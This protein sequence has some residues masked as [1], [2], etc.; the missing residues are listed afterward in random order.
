MTVAPNL[1]YLLQAH[2]LMVLSFLTAWEANSKAEAY[3]QVHLRFMEN[4]IDTQAIAMYV[5]VYCQFLE[6]RIQYVTDQVCI[7]MKAN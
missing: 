5:Y 1:P 3:S 6:Y 2:S 7:I 4:R